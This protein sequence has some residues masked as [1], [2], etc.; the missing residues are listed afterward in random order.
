MSSIKRSALACA[1]IV[2][3]A[4]TATA[5]PAHAGG[6]YFFCDRDIGAF[7]TC[8]HGADHQLERTQAR[9]LNGSNRVCATQKWGS[10][11]G[12]TNQYSWACADYL[13]ERWNGNGYV[14]FPAVR[15]AEGWS[16]LMRGQFYT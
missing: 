1:A 15:N 11:A 5:T 9:D 2:A 7:D 13:A 8:V 6:P 16:Q 4:C 12:S 14:G 3:G 10:S